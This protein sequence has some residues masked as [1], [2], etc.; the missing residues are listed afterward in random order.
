MTG[1]GCD[2]MGFGGRRDGVWGAMKEGE[3][4]NEQCDGRREGFW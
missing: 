1:K 3:G 4:S 2:G